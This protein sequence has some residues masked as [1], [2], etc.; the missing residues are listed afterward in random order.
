[1]KSTNN[2][3][4]SAF[5]WEV[6]LLVL[7]LSGPLAGCRVFG[8]GMAW[9]KD[10]APFKI[11]L[12]RS[13]HFLTAPN[14]GERGG[15][16]ILFLSDESVECEDLANYGTDP[17][18]EEAFD[19]NGL[20]FQVEVRF[21]SGGFDDGSDWEGIYLEG[22]SVGAGD[23]VER[24]LSAVA[25]H[26]G[27][28]FPLGSDGGYYSSG[29]SVVPAWLDVRT[30]EDDNVN[31]KFETLWWKGGFDGAR[32]DHGDTSFETGDYGWETGR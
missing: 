20:I 28:L 11:G 31:G 22:N 8:D 24:G 16:G 25:F 15:E 2:K 14:N 32:C 27:M 21:D 19:G 12:L 29:G 10:G 23:D 30:F 17:D 6:S 13:A 18:V 4:R 26:D 7:S 9:A 3:G 5:G 1:M